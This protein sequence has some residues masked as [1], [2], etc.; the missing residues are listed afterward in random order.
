MGKCFSVKVALDDFSIR[1][2][3]VIKPLAGKEP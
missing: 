1:E 3:F 2:D